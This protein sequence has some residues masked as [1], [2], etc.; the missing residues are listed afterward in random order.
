M[1]TEY[2]YIRFVER[3]TAPGRITTGWDCL[4]RRHGSL[5]GEVAFTGAWRQYVFRP[6][7]TCEF[8]VGCLR[9]IADFCEQLTQHWQEAQRRRRVEQVVAS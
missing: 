4:N 6:S 1:R 9:D 2:Q 8:S 3:A 5:L 7:P